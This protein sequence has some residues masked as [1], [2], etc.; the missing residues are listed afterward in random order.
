[1][2][3]NRPPSP[4]LVDSS[5]AP[6]DRLRPLATADDRSQDSTGLS[7]LGTRAA[8]SHGE[9]TAAIGDR[10]SPS[11]PLSSI[12]EADLL[13]GYG[14][15]GCGRCEGTGAILASYH[16]GARWRSCPVC[17]GTGRKGGRA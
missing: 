4:N 15:S 2:S 11:D 13:R 12:S 9:R 10:V 1:M 6:R 8:T 5:E 17:E 3:T 16:D 7:T 14:L